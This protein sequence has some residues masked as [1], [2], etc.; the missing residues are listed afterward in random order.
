[1]S[2]I[3]LRLSDDVLILSDENLANPHKTSNVVFF[4]SHS[5]RSMCVFSFGKA[6]ISSF[7]GLKKNLKKTIFKGVAKSSHS[8]VVVVKVCARV[9]VSCGKRVFRFPRLIHALVHTF[10]QRLSTTSTAPQLSFFVSLQE[11][12]G[13]VH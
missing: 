12:R 10:A 2:I 5:I 4:S 11:K 1:M 8:S 6:E 7:L 9:W 3:V 13:S